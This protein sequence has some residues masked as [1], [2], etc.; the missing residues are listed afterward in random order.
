LS[1]TFTVTA[2]GIPL[3]AYQWQISTNGGSTWNNIPGATSNSYV[4]LPVTT[5]DHN[6]QYHCLVSNSFSAVTSNAAILT[7]TANALPAFTSQPADVVL[8]AANQTATF[9]VVASG[10]PIP[11]LQWQ[12]ST[13]GGGTWSN[14]I[15][16]TNASYSFT[17]LAGDD[18]KSFHCVATNSQGSVTSSMALLLIAPL[19]TWINPHGGSWPVAANWSNNTVASGTGITA[20][21]SRIDLPSN[22]TDDADHDGIL[23]LMEFALNTSPT[24]SNTLPIT[25][26]LETIGTDHYFRITVP[27]NPSATN[28]IYTVEVCSGL[29]SNA[30]TATETQVESDTSTELRVRGTTVGTARRF[31]RLK[32]TEKP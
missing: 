9:T 3:P 23:N 19:P 8:L 11:T 17:A 10:T 6:N 26:D 5:G 2:S 1:A 14:L 31:I 28:L 15:G 29:A 18:N 32:V 24:E 20:D 21:F 13:N 12:V 25:Y 7:V 4:T 27:K 30:W 22:A 16:A